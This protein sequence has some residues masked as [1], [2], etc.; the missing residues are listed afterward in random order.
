MKNRCLGQRLGWVS[1]RR[2]A[3]LVGKMLAS[4]P[5]SEDVCS[6]PRPGTGQRLG[7]GPNRF[8][9]LHCIA[10]RGKLRTN[11]AMARHQFRSNRRSLR[12]Q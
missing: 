2:G 3:A 1:A 8:Q 5:R 6:H 7:P 12:H 4:L 11:R 9:P 10:G